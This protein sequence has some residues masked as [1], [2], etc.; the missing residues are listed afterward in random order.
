VVVTAQTSIELATAG[1]F[2]RGSQ[3]DSSAKGRD[4][5]R[6]GHFMA[7]RCVRS[8]SITGAVEDLAATELHDDEYIKDAEPHRDHSKEIARYDRLGV[9]RT[10]AAENI[11]WGEERI[12][13]ELKLKLG[14]RGDG[15]HRA[16][17]GR[18]VKVLSRRARAPRSRKKLHL[19]GS[20]PDRSR[21]RRYRSARPELDKLPR[22]S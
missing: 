19:V 7:T 8:N 18:Y 1:R 15:P 5:L 3:A 22:C 6:N 20:I 2:A 21:N 17:S 16:A 4:D 10:M 11:T 13:N 9:I 12:A 14:I